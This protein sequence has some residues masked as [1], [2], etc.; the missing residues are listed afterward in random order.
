MGEPVVIDFRN[1]FCL[2]LGFH[3][4]TS[5]LFILVTKIHLPAGAFSRYSRQINPDQILILYNIGVKVSY[6]ICAFITDPKIFPYIFS[7][8][9]IFIQ[10]VKCSMVG[11]SG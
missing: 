8:G 7:F 9:K 2:F 5:H 11:F 1:P 3:S 10:L 4:D 6:V